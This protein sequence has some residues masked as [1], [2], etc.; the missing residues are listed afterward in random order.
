VPFALGVVTL[1]LVLA[2]LRQVAGANETKR[3]YRQVEEASDERRQ[4]L[5]QMLERSVH[6]RRRFAGQL[7]EQAMSAYASFTAL[8]GTGRPT[9]GLASV[10]AAASQVVRGDLARHADS[11]Q[12]LLLAISPLEGGSRPG[13]GLRT[14]IAAY[15]A[16]TYGDGRPPRLTVDLVEPLALDWVTETVLLQVVQDALHNVR[17]HSHATAVA[18]RVAREGDVVVVHVADDGIGFDPA[19][20][21]HESG[22]AA[23]RA[24]AQVLGGTLAVRSR[25]GQGTVVSAWLGPCTEGDGSPGATGEGEAALPPVPVP[26]PGSPRLRLVSDAGPRRP[27]GR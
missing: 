12:E 19:A 8:A 2:G 21:D 26:V 24:S 3:L 17:R 23:M 7:H 27:G 10:V 22:L 13:E 6:D 20:V 25:P 1:L 4:L 18:V 11:L 9:P 5:T 16:G 15:L 14:P